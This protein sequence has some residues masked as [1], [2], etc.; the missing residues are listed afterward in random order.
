MEALDHSRGKEITVEVLLEA[1]LD[2]GPEH[3][4]RD[5][6][7]RAILVANLRLVH[8]GDRCRGDG[9]TELGIDLLDR[10]AERLFDRRPRLALREWRQAVLERGEIAGELAADDVVARGE[11]L[12]ELDVGRPERGERIGE[13]G[14]V[15]ARPGA[16]LAERRRDPREERE[17]PR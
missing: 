10:R 9:R 16:V 15:A 6:G 17:R 13:L 2:A 11:E 12:S 5:R 4:D 1:L 8:L 14:F 7:E 3:L